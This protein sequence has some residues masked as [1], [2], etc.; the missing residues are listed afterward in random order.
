M[1]SLSVEHLWS[2]L[3]ATRFGA[4]DVRLRFE[5]GGEVFDNTV[6]QIPRFLQ[7]HRRA[8]ALADAL[9]SGNCM[10][11]VAWGGNP[12]NAS[13]LSDGVKNGFEALQ[14]TGFGVPCINEWQATLYPDPDDEAHVW[15]LRS[16]DLGNGK[17][18]RDTLLWHA[19]AHEMPIY[20]KAS[21]LTFLLDPSASVMLHVY[22]D[23]GMDVI[24]F[25]PAKLDGLHS[26]FS[27]WLLDYD[28]ERMA[29]LF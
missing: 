3:W 23:R 1:K 6:Q 2:S 16:C 18:A 10:A 14:F 27:E 22:D 21:V 26:N 11:V 9:F 8:S 5:L 28:R 4:E 15:A 24:A 7:A 25:D 17:V 20:P 19:V 29:K 12:P 13:G